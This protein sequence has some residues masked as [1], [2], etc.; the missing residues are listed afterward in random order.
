MCHLSMCVFLH[1]I[2]LFYRSVY[3]I[4]L[5]NG[6]SHNMSDLFLVR[7]LWFLQSNSAISEEL[8]EAVDG[9]GC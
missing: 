1:Y 4:E 9:W 7:L 2:C 6:S 5:Y 8:R 3:L